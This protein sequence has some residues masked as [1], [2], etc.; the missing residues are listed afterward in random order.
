MSKAFEDP[1][2]I[3]GMG[4]QFKLR[5]D[6]LNAGEN[7]IGWK[8]G[9]GASVSL[10]RLQ[11]DAP[12]IGFL[13]DKTLLP[14][15]AAVSV[16]GYVKPAIEP[17]IAVYMGRDLPGATDRDTTRAALASLGPAIELADVHFPP[18]DVE[19]ILAG[20]IYN[21]HVILGQADSG[22][23]G[24]VLDGLIGRVSRN[25][26]D[27][28]AVTDLQALTGNIVDIVN[29]VAGLLSFFGELLCAGDV[30]ITGSILP[31]LSIVPNEEIMYRLEPID[32]VSIK[33]Q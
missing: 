21:R 22:R 10:K 9:F 32:V 24:C 2:I 15:N 30:I 29:H 4:K 8:V 17:E 26:Q 11:L 33:L 3:R 5:R 7:P 16:A 12:L 18:D 1:R 31:P 20:N 13:T 23:G 6:R 25:G 28:P 14:S 27:L 19:L